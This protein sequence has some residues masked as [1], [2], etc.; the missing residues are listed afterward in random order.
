[1]SGASYADCSS[2]LS[3]Q[4]C[5]PTCPSGY[6]MIASPSTLTLMC[7]ANG[8]FDGSNSLVCDP[9]PCDAN[10]ITH[11]VDGATYTDCD[12]KSTGDTCTPQC[13]PGYG[14]ITSPST[15]TLTCDASGNF[16]GSNELVCNECFT[17]V[18]SDGTSTCTPCNGPRPKT[19]IPRMNETTTEINPTPASDLSPT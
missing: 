5:E 9:F 8:D 10:N 15:V 12:G 14:V 2:K 4:T 3:H 13:V 18:V 19:R 17:G 11:A 1:M 7:D 6:R 16:D